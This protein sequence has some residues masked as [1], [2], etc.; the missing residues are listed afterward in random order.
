MTET[1]AKSG[2]PGTSTT[3]VD[4]DATPDGAAPSGRDAAGRAAVPADAMSSPKFTR[5][6]GMAPPPGEPAADKDGPSDPKRPAGPAVA[7]GSATVPIVTKGKGGASGNKAGRTGVMQ[8]GKPRGALPDVAR[9]TGA[10]GGAPDT[11]A[12]GGVRTPRASPRAPPPRAGEGKR[13]GPA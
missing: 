1:T 2:G 11:G 4:E 7:K 12:C 3:P 10:S 5:P 8:Q 6:P 9:A 13:P